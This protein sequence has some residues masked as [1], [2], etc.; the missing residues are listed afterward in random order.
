MR[1]VPSVVAIGSHAEATAAEPSRATTATFNAASAN[2]QIKAL[3]Q[4]LVSAVMAASEDVGTGFAEEARRIHYNE[5]P[6]RPIRGQTTD[7]EYEALQDEGIE[8]IRLAVPR[9]EELS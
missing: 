2:A 1:R 8:V 5:A 3:Y 6:E 7:E 4:Q 9:K